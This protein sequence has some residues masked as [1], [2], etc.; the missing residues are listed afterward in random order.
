MI[1]NVETY[2]KNFD[3]DIDVTKRFGS[4]G[5]FLKLSFENELNVR[6]S[7][8]FL[9]SETNVFGDNP[10]N[11]IKDQYTYAKNKVNNFNPRLTYRLLLIGKKFYV[12]LQYDYEKTNRKIRKAHL[13]KI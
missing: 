11:I 9:N 8:D 13:I 7:D 5:A 2:G 4:N 3:N 12:E 6:E 1:S 10:E